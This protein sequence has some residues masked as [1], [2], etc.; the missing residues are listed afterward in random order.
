M[1]TITSYRLEGIRC[2][3]EALTLSTP[4]GDINVHIGRYEKRPVFV[5]ENWGHLGNYQRKGMDAW[6]YA[7][8]LAHS[9]DLKCPFVVSF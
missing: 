1:T 8:V 6:L 2:N 4:T 7:A 3:G 9:G 5:I